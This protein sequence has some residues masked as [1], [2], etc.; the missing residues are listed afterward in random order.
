MALD[1]A[2]AFAKVVALMESIT[3]MQKVYQ[4]VPDAFG[5]SI[6]AFVAMSPIEPRDEANNLIS[7]KVTFYIVMGYKTTLGET[8]AEAKL[9]AGVTD[10]VRKFYQ[11]RKTDFDGTVENAE[12]DMSLA[13]L[14][15]YE[16]VA[17]QEYRRFPLLIK[18]EQSENI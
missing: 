16:V 13:A 3:G 15:E 7:V 6:T 5:R 2:A 1:F 17:G 14:P 11:A 4:G 12:L 8:D 10:L 9:I 18:T